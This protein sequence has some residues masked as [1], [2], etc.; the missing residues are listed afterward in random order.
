[1]TTSADRVSVQFG[2][3]EAAQVSLAEKAK[4]LTA[5]LEELAKSLQPV[6]ETWYASGSE[7]GLTA[8]QSETRLRAAVAEIINTIN[9]FSG[10]VGDAYALQ[11][12][13]ETTNTNYFA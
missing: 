3:L 5:H 7:A 2:A 11:R 9:K 10:K 13:L 4:T 8:E 1:M 6:K 12:Q